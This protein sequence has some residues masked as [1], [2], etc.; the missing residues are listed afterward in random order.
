MFETIESPV[1]ARALG[2]FLGACLGDAAG[3]TLEFLGR[4][5][6]REEVETAMTMPGGGVLEVAPGQITDDC[7]L[8]ISLARGLAGSDSFD[9]DKIADKY[10]A[11]VSS[12]PFDIGNTTQSSLGCV[13]N[14]SIGCAQSMMKAAEEFCMNSKANGAL[15]RIVPLAI[16]AYQ[17][18]NDVIAGFAQ[19]ENSLSHP[20]ESVWHASAAYCIAIAQLIREPDNHA[21]AIGAVEAWVEKNANDEVQSWLSDARKNIDIPYYPQV[22]FVKI[23]FTHAFRHLYLNSTFEESLIETLLGGGDTDTNAC[24]V[25]GLMGA[26]HGVSQLGE[27]RTCA[28]LNCDTSLGQRRPAFLSASQVPQ[29][30]LRLLSRIH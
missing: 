5:P 21:A 26:L 25:G 17:D 29:L 28:V 14:P 30:T 19:Q 9:I 27:E 4:S 13:V 24:I 1:H 15:M 6:T 23:A 7:E 20:N 3:A 16:W 11:W 2:A 18:T 22:G 10:S 8:A 12:K